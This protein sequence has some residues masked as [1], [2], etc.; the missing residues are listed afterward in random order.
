MNISARVMVAVVAATFVCSGLLGSP[1]A[2]AEPPAATCQ[3]D[4]GFA[5]LHGAIP[6]VVGDCA[7][8]AIGLGSGNVSQRTTNGVLLWRRYDNWTGF[9]NGTH[10][11]VL[12][13][14]GVQ[15]RA[16]DQLFP[17][18]AG[19]NEC[20]PAVAA[21]ALPTT[22]V[23]GVRPGF[24]PLW[25]IGHGD[26]YNCA[27]FSGPEAVLVLAADPS[28]PN[29]LDT[30]HLYTDPLKPIDTDPT[31]ATAN[32]RHVSQNGIPC[33]PTYYRQN[34]NGPWILTT[35]D[36]PGGRNLCRDGMVSVA[37]DPRADCLQHGGV[38]D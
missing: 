34:G 19:K 37:Q 30:D 16:S 17:W 5:V 12:G 35:E 4:S 38:A 20:G 9:N 18:E 6:S 29:N 31:H 14:C 22:Q 36:F 11:W 2:L 33:E 8:P 24:N 26:A 21:A 27:D 1:V 7:E 13:P 28:D 25:Y 15:D 3:F 23:E 10:V 32:P